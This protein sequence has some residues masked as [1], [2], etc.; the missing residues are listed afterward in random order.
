MPCKMETRKRLRK[1][2]ETVASGNTNP[3]KKT[4]NACIEEAHEL[5]RKRL[6]STLP[7]SHE[8]HI[9]D[10]GFNSMN[11]YNLV[12][13]FVPMLQAMKIPDAKAAVDNGWKMLETIPAWQLDKV[14]SKTADILEA[15]RGKKK[16][17]FATLM[18]KCHLK[19]AE[20]EPTFQK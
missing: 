15:Q 18:D 6:E 9:A 13:K 2:R 17:H 1:L 20:L 10:N 3:D 5:T 14:K 12:H 16:V 7:G 4:K 19:N 11:H 8:D